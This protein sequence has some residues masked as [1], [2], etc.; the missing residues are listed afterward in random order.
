[1]S[2]LSNRGFSVVE[3][4]VAL[5]IG[6]VVL[7]AAI[8]FLITH[9]RSLEGNDIREN[10]SR[11]T[12]Y[13][14]ALLR[15]DVQS[16]GIDIKSSTSFG[17]VAVWP[18]APNDTL[19]LL[20]V[21][22]VPVSAPPHDI[23][24]TANGGSDPA[25]GL[26]TCA[27]RCVD[28]L[29][30]DGVTL[31]LASGDLARIQIGSTR[32]LIIVDA[33]TINSSTQAEIDFTNADTLLHQPASLVGPVQIKLASTYVQELKPIMF[34][35]DAQERLIRA[36]GLN[37]DGTPKGEVVAYSVEQFEVS[38]V[39]DDGDELSQANPYDADDSNDYDDIVAV[40]IKVTVKAHRV[41]PRV[42]G[43]QMLKR[44][45]RWQ[46]SPRNLRYERN[47]V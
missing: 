31:D 19:L 6:T 2:K 40:I 24:P 12:R 4:I 32:R 29:Y 17:T 23:D 7:S 22:Y 27:T 37:L 20:Y 25:P 26:G 44:T 18:G 41:D 36:E 34:Y 43:G 46:I 30:E 15:R 35:V 3:L 21:P 8:T 11:N 5:L 42:N 13:I 39:F 9:I 16:A 14:G 33:I 38:L 1:M 10:V 47:R 28:V 45:A